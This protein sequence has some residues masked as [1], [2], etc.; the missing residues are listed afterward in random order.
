MSPGLTG[1]ICLW[2]LVFR[3]PLLMVFMQHIV[4]RKRV[5]MCLCLWDAIKRKNAWRLCACVYV[6]RITRI[7]CNSLL[8]EYL[9]E[10]GH[11]PDNFYAYQLRPQTADTLLASEGTLRCLVHVPDH[12]DTECEYG[13]FTLN[14]SN[15][16]NV[17]QQ[18]GEDDLLEFCWSGRWMSWQHCAAYLLSDL[19]EVSD[20]HT[21]E[22]LTTVNRF[23]ARIA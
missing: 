19:L 1:K 7:L 6:L 18:M 23:P 13:Y 21:I 4:F 5:W 15:I 22:L 11:W 14:P 16:L 10:K 2:N 8:L 3:G 9:S 12:P 17:G 20:T